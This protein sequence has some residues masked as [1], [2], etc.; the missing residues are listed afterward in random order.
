MAGKELKVDIKGLNTFNDDLSQT[1]V[2]F[3]KAVHPL[4]QEL[5]DEAAAFYYPTGFVKD[6]DIK[7]S[8][9]L[10]ATLMNAKFLEKKE[11]DGDAAP[12]RGQFT[13]RKKIYFDA[14]PFWE[15]S[16]LFLKE[17]P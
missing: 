15:V 3:A 4:L 6:I 1:S 11:E 10:H 16:C 14:R 2:L 17:S 12:R 8:V 5:A 7:A 13:R 9:R